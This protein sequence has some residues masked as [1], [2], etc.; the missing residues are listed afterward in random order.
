M[1]DR[2]DGEEEQKAMAV[3]TMAV[4]TE[5]CWDTFLSTVFHLSDLDPSL[6]GGSLLEEKNEVPSK[7]STLFLS[8]SVFPP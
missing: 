2:R 4:L 6:G 3:F 5:Q 1:E 7:A 8:S